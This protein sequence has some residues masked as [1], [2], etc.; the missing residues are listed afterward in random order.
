MIDFHH[1][2][3][4]WSLH[5]PVHVRY[6]EISEETFLQNKPIFVLNIEKFETDQHGGIYKNGYGAGGT[7]LVDL[8]NHLVPT[9]QEAFPYVALWLISFYD[10]CSRFHIRWY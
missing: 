1:Q 9:V 7:R 10:F 3:W 5:L 6:Q 4:Y 2:I 8:D